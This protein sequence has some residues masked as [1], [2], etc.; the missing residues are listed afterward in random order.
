[1]PQAPAGPPASGRGD[2][3]ASDTADTIGADLLAVVARARVAGVN[4]ESA[5]KD[6]LERSLSSKETSR[7]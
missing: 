2:D 6:A 1:V 7:N 3:T 4:A 5:L